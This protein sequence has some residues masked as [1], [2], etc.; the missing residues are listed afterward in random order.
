MSWQTQGEATA[1]VYG[2][3]SADFAGGSFPTLCS[4]KGGQMILALAV[5]T[6]STVIVRHNS[7]NI[8]LNSGAQLV[9]DSMYR[10]SIDL[11]QDATFSIRFGATLT[12]RYIVLKSE[13]EYP[14]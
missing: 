11:P 2:S 1:I 12:V 13:P 6:A 10:F 7:V 4:M 9:A 3:T 5:N 8:T 14:V